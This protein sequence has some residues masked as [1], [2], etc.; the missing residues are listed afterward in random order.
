MMREHPTLGSVWISTRSHEFARVPHQYAKTVV[1]AHANVIMIATG[2]MIADA[3]DKEKPDFGFIMQDGSVAFV[4]EGYLYWTV[5]P[6]E[7]TL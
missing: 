3:T 2:E 4:S 5:F 1:R 6:V 7:H